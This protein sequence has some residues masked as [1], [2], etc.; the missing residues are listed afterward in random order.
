MGHHKNSKFLCPKTIG[1]VYM[2]KEA[3]LAEETAASLFG[4]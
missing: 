2:R 1:P 4:L 3:R